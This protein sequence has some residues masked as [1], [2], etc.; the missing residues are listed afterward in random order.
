[1][2]DPDDF[3][4][5]KLRDFVAT[6]ENDPDYAARRKQ[7]ER[8]DK[9]VA[10]EVSRKLKAMTALKVIAI[11]AALAII[12]VGILGSLPLVIAV[13]ASLIAFLLIDKGG[14]KLLDVITIGRIKRKTITM[15]ENEG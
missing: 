15:M 4:L 10:I 14:K 8:Q 11:G 6:F 2:T 12:G 13:P 7:R 1:M 9:M 3:D 5:A